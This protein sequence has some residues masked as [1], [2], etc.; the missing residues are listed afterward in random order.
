MQKGLAVTG[1]PSDSYAFNN[2]LYVSPSLF[3][4]FGGENPENGVYL[5]LNGFILPVKGESRVSPNQISIG[6]IHR[7]MMRISKIDS[8]NPKG[9]FVSL[10]FLVFVPTADNVSKLLALTIEVEVGKKSASAPPMLELDEKKL[11][12][13]FR[14]SLAKHVCDDAIIARA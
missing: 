13:I 9:M 2:C 6:S 5:E 14:G 12:E 11:E 8:L 1:L 7:Q 10:F 3:A 4:T